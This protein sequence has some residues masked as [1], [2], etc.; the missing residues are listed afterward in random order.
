MQRLQVLENAVTAGAQQVTSAEHR[1]AAAEARVDAVEIAPRARTTKVPGA[2]AYNAPQEL[3]DTKLLTKPKAFGSN[4]EEWPSWSFKM[5]AYLGALDE[6]TQAISD[7][8]DQVWN[9]NLNEP[10]AESRSRQLFILVLLLGGTALQMIKPVGTSEGYRAWRVLQDCHEPDRPGRHAGLLQELIGFQTDNVLGSLADFDWKLSKYENQSGE[11]IGDKIKIAI[12]QRGLQDDQMRAHRVLHSSRLLT[13]E[14]V[15]GE[16]QAILTT[17]QAL[18]GGPTPMD[19]SALFQKGEGKGKGKGKKGKGKGKEKGEVEKADRQKKR[20]YHCHKECHLK[21]ECRKF[22]TEGK[23][24]GKE[25]GV[26]AVVHESE[27]GEAA[28]PA[29]QQQPQQQQEAA[30]PANEV[31]PGL[32]EMWCLAMEAVVSSPAQ[33]QPSSQKLAIPLTSS[34]AAPTSTSTIHRRAR[35]RAAAAHRAAAAEAEPPELEANSVDQNKVMVD[36]G[37]ARSA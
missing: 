29:P 27:S 16:A 8:L 10:E 13:W 5:M 31:P 37:A 9:R 32:L 15:R 35:R 1:A 2:A 20:C 19:V 17:R 6:L 14:Q 11:R 12:V 23:G 22:L 24:K 21:F 26:S 30:A 36:T 34:T 7:P 25:K 3:V 28:Q 18:Q 4:E 33:L